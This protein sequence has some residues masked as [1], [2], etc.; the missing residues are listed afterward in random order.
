M[1]E[2]PLNNGRKLVALELGDKTHHEDKGTDQY[3]DDMVE[4]FN[5]IEE[6]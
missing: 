2:I 1:A 6:E 5:S 3:L 4:T